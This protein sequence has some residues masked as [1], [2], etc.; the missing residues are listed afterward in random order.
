[1]F[2][3][4]DRLVSDRLPK[5][6]R[7]SCRQKI[8]ENPTQIQPI[9]RRARGHGHG[10][11]HGGRGCFGGRHGRR[12]HPMARQLSRGREIEWACREGIAK[13]SRSQIWMLRKK[14]LFLAGAKVAQVN[15]GP[16]VFPLRCP[17]TIKNIV[18]AFFMS[19]VP[20]DSAFNSKYP[21]SF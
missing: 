14:I 11:G 17:V 13:I 15:I 10:H 3:D 7:K 18:H 2:I 6:E 19:S 21:I 8:P 20:Y 9:L 16:N 12:T 5:H 1:M 4:E